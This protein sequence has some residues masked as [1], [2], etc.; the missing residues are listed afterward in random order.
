MSQT[1]TDDGCDSKSAQ[2]VCTA[3]MTSSK[4]EETRNSS[5]RI[6]LENELD[7][8]SWMKISYQQEAVLTKPCLAD[9]VHHH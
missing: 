5:A 1:H 6:I 7:V 3:G 9:S 8:M 4:G 2:R